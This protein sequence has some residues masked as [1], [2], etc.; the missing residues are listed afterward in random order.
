LERDRWEDGLKVTP[1]LKI[2]R[3]KETCAKFP[4]RETNLGKHLGDGQLSGPRKAIK[5]EHMVVL[6]VLE[7]TF[8]LKEDVPP[9]PPQTSL[10]ISGRVPSV[11]RVAHAF[12]KLAILRPL[13]TSYYKKPDCKGMILTICWQFSL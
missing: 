8:E 13:F 12:Q 11:S 5:P 3:T 2:S 4:V 10:P 9:R 1:A 6:F 7:L